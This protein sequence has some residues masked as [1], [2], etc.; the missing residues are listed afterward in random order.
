MLCKILIINML[1]YKFKRFIFNKTLIQRFNRR[2]HPVC[3]N[4]QTQIP[5]D[6]DS[7]ESDST[8]TDR[9][10]AAS[11]G[12]ILRRINLHRRRSVR[13]EECSKLGIYQRQIGGYAKPYRP[14]RNRLH[15][16]CP[17]LQSSRIR[18]DTPSFTNL[19]HFVSR[20][21]WQ[22]RFLLL[23]LLP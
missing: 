13:S 22:F 16:T 23:P 21:I 4:C 9:M 20:Q 2:P 3:K 12:I 10:K 17:L 8:I 11:G 5:D 1:D 15:C 18:P 7:L 19:I 6:M 14:D